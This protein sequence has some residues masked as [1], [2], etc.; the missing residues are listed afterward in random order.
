M[1]FKEDCVCAAIGPLLLFFVR[2]TSSFCVYVCVE[3]ETTFMV[4]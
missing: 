1:K 4:I 3:E 2:L